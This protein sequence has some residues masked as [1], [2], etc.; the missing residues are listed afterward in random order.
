MSPSIADYTLVSLQKAFLLRSCANS[1]F[2]N[3]TRPCLLY[4]IKRCSAPCV[5]YITKH[6]YDE[7]IRD[8]KKFLAG[9]TKRVEG[10][11][12]RLMQYASENQMFEEAARLRD[13][14][15]SI[16]HIQKYQ[17]IY[18]KDMRNID[19]FAVK[20]IDGKSCIYGMFY[21]NGTNYGNKSFFPLHDFN[22]TETEILESFL[23]QFYVDKE[24]P[25]K[26][27]INLNPKLYTHVKDM[28][29]QK[30]GKKSKYYQT[31]SW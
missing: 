16:R 14:L 25:P 30:S 26:I 6:K 4:D 17:S 12:G 10:K 3:R 31:K 1:V 21:R 19:I 2:N 23:F 24:I 18:I 9:K 8:A 13:R 5:G 7:S 22:A 11:L 28:L 29:H 20:V 27:L 15:K